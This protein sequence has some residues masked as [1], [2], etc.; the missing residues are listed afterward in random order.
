MK[1]LILEKTKIENNSLNSTWESLKVFSSSNCELGEG[2]LWSA[3]THS[4]FWVD[5]LSKR[6]YK[7]EVETGDEFYWSLPVAASSIAAD[8]LSKNSFWLLTETHLCLFHV[9]SGKFDF[10]YPLNLEKGYRTNDG[11]VGPDGRYWFGTMLWSPKPGKGEIFS[12]GKMGDIRKEKSSVAIPNTFCWINQ[13]ELLVSDSL[14]QICYRLDKS[15]RHSQ[16]F[17]DKKGH[18]GTPDG[19]AIDR[20]G[21]IWVAV[22]GEGR[23]VCYNPDGVMKNEIKLPVSQPS[24]CCFGGKG[25]STL[26]ITTAKEGLIDDGS[27]SYALSGLVFMINLDDTGAVVETF[28]GLKDDC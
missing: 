12:I 23:V 25:L 7:K 26:F 27:Q 15:T 4:L 6:L 10:V 9:Q 8:S 14:E 3:A 2:P 21:N 16:V 19:G 20:N 11:V 22:W 18:Q 24:S 13:N 17:I 28:N 1:S 5:I